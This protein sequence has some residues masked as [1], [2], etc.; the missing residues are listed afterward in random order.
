MYRL[1]E[2]YYDQ[3]PPEYKALYNAQKRIRDRYEQQRK[4]KDI[5]ERITKNVINYINTDTSLVEKLAQRI[6]M[7]VDT[8]KAVGKIKELDDMIKNIGSK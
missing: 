5:E 3:M 2:I 4:E 1:E 8:S 6:M 7:D